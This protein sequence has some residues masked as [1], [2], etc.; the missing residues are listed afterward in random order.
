MPVLKHTH[1]YGRW[2]TRGGEMHFKC[3]DPQ[4]THFAPRSL[5]I[6]KESKCSKCE[7]IVIFDWKQAERAKTLCLECQNTKEA[8]ELKARKSATEDLMSI[9]FGQ[10]KETL[11]DLEKENP[12]A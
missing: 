10:T 1:T 5:V 7:N 4:C 8:R 9:A 3:L 6:G 12:L 2:K 11:E